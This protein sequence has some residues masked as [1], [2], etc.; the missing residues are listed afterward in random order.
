LLSEIARKKKSIPTG[1]DFRANF[2]IKNYPQQNNGGNKR[3]AARAGRANII[4]NDIVALGQKG[5]S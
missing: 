5:L 4:G 1:I 2:G 3:R